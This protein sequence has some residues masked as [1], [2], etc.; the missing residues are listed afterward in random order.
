MEVVVGGQRPVRSTRTQAADQ[1][2]GG[3][4]ACALAVD[5]QRRDVE[6][7]LRDPDRQV[8]LERAVEPGVERI[9]LGGG[10]IEVRAE[11][12]QVAGRAADDRAQRR[13]PV[14]EVV[15]GADLLRPGDTSFGNDDVPWLRV[16]LDR[17]RAAVG[18]DCVVVVR[19]DGAGDCTARAPSTGCF[20]M[21]ITV[22]VPGCS[23]SAAV[24]AP[25]P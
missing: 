13:Q 6:R 19:I 7:V 1:I 14:V 8:L 25:W 23:R 15:S 21:T 9:R 4:V 3:E 10:R 22:P 17:V 20:P 2:V 18:P 11:A 12:L 5:L 16:W 24:W